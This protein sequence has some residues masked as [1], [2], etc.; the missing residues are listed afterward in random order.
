MPR[1]GKITPNSL[2]VLRPKMLPNSSAVEPKPAGEFIALMACLMSLVALTIDSILPALTQI[3]DTLNVAHANDTQMVLSSVFFGMAFGL[4]LFGPLADSFGRK[5]TL[6]LGI[7]IFLIGDLIS[8]FAQSFETMIAGRVIQGFGAA[9]CRVVTTTMIRDKFKGA[10]MGRVMSL[11][12]MVFILVP[13][14]APTIGQVIL[15]FGGYRSIFGFVFIFALACLIWLQVR[16]VETQAK[17]HKRA[18]S[19]TVIFAGFKETIT[20]PVTQLYILASGIIFGSFIG[21]LSTSQ[22][23]LQVLYD[24]GEQFPLYF[25]I[26]TIAIGFSSFANSKL[27]MKIKMERLCLIA[28]FS[29]AVCSIGFILLLSANDLH[30]S[31]PSFLLYITL[32]FF[33]F[34]MLFGNLSTLAVQPLGHI[35]GVATSTV[36]SI[37]TFIS[38]FIGGMI[39]SH[40]N[41]TVVPLVLGFMACAMLSFCLVFIAKQRA[42]RSLKNS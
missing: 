40:Y 3:G 39:G 25:G 7:T 1:K 36:S 30:L 41:G 14:L 21:Y 34:G 8:I 29:S 15:L 19:R 16:Q 42:K 9:S 17:E 26:L 20:H 6:Y 27:V 13:A 4:I 33:C 37:Q 10:Q 24:T 22:Q 2:K 32:T 31:L 35:A 18:F 28:L 23:I 38:V 11:I 5:R 12:M